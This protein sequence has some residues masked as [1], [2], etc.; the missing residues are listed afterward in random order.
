MNYKFPSLVIAVMTRESVRRALLQGIKAGQLIGYLDSHIHHRAAA[1]GVRGIPETVRDQILR[2]EEERC[3]FVASQAYLYRSAPC[4]G[5]G[6]ISQW[7]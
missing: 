7:L 4:G 5:G 1:R 3:R 2:W 6:L